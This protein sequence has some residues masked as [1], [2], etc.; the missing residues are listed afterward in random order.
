MPPAEDQT[1]AGAVPNRKLL[2]RA[3]GHAL[4]PRALGMGQNEGVLDLHRLR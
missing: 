2:L 1:P 4:R 3:D